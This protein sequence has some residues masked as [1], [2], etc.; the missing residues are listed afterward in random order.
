[1]I[2]SE[3]VGVRKRRGGGER[4]GKTKHDNNAGARRMGYLFVTKQPPSFPT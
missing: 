3:R 2:E 4:K 1:M